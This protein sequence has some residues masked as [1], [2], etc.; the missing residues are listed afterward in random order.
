MLKIQR[1][2]RPVLR[3]LTL[4]C[5]C[6][7]LYRTCAS[8]TRTV[9]A[10]YRGLVCAS[11]CPEYQGS[12]INESLGVNGLLGPLSEVSGCWFHG[13]SCRVLVHSLV[14]PDNML[15]GR[16]LQDRIRSLGSILAMM[17][18]CGKISAAGSEITRPRSPAHQLYQ[19]VPFLT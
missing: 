14:Q 11:Y 8:I 5:V 16:A 18:S 15:T 13:P 19:Q 6:V 9:A 2:P 12:V 17:G 10:V 3:K 1:R 7:S 4:M